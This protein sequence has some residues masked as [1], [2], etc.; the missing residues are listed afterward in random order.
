MSV[1]GKIQALESAR[2]AIVK[3]TPARERMNLF[4]DQNTFVE[5][6]AFTKV[7]GQGTGVVTGYGLVEGSPVYAFAQDS[8]EMGGGV[9][10]VHAAKIAKVY[11]LALKTGVP[12]VGIYDSKG[13]RLEEGNDTLAAYGDML[14][15]VNTLSG[16]VP[17]ISVVVG[18]CAGT[19]AMIACSADFVVMSKEAALYMTAPNV[20]E[21]NGEGCQDAGT[22]QAA[23]KSGVAHLISEDENAALQDARRLVSMLPLNNLAAAPY[24]DFSEKSGAADALRAACEDVNS[25]CVKELVMNIVDEDSALELQGEFASEGVR[26]YLATIAGSTVGMVAT[27]GAR[28]CADC[29]AKIAR[30]VSICDTYQI[31]VVTLVNVPGFV[32][33][34]KAEI[35]GSIRE[36]AKL[37]HIYAEATTPKIALITGAAYGAAY[38][39]LA[40][41]SANA[42]LT[43]AWPSAAISS[44]EPA[45]AVAISYGDKITAE[46][47]RAD[48]EKEYMETEAS[49]YHAAADG[50]IDGIIDPA[51]TRATLISA[52]DVLAAKRVSKLP[53]KHSNIPM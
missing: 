16:V 47:S 5:L 7:G 17:Q 3:A 23:A 24:V 20:A 18:P 14:N 6:D 15:R 35:S 32:Q 30:F 38:I 49:A 1:V 39:A 48:V 43:Y 44:L 36:A 9:G 31:P 40:G 2:Q 51:D 8:T 53:K 29:C 52:L 27:K 37:A 10:R 11:D 19:A 50:S 41:R 22:A 21:A 4:F 12:I 33:S 42:D 25:S 46:K 13:A 28:L 45:T 34:S 26:T